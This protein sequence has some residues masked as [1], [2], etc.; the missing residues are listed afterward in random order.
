MPCAVRTVAMSGELASISMGGEQEGGL[1]DAEEL[2]AAAAE[3]GFAFT[4]RQFELWRYRGLL[5]RPVRQLGERSRWVY[6]AETAAQLTRLLELRS[7]IRNLELIRI[8]LWSE[9]YPLELEPVRAAL[10]E[11]LERVAAELGDERPGGEIPA[12]ASRLAAARSRNLLGRGVRMG[13]D[14]RTRAYALLLAIVFGAEAEIAARA[15]DAELLARLI[16]AE[17]TGGGAFVSSAVAPAAVT[18]QPL[19]PPTQLVT[20]LEQADDADLEQAR[21]VLR[22]ATAWWPLML[23]LVGERR[24]DGAALAGLARDFW[25]VVPPDLVPVLLA[26]VLAALRQP[27]PSRARTGAPP[28]IQAGG[29]PA[30]GEA[31]QAIVGAGV[32]VVARLGFDG[33]TYREVARQAGTTHGA[34]GYHFKTREELIHEVALEARRIAV[35]GAS[36]IPPGGRLDQFGR[37]LAR[38]AEEDLDAHLFS[39]ELTLQTRRRPELAKE[40]RN[41]YESYFELTGEALEEVGIAGD[42]DLA[43]LVFAAIDGLV[44]QQVVN[45]DP[46]ETEEAVGELQRLLAAIRDGDGD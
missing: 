3:S 40:V 2:A 19:P 7:S 12:L 17:A 24:P 15:G 13:K 29:R 20:V 9:G 31:R 1:L 42:E 27:Q 14:E 45:D 18:P 4:P 34:V 32:K 22:A 21:R 6:P 8:L 46:Q 16:G 37:A 10:A 5:P 43:R 11:S 36:I 30:R 33:L 28:P 23:S 41:L 38:S 26:G 44:I 25:S 39:Y 35:A